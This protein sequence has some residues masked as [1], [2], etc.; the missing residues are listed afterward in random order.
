MQ[1]G[2]V[3]QTAADISEM[4]RDFGFKPTTDLAMG[5]EKLVAWY[6]DYYHNDGSNGNGN[7][8]GNSNNYMSSRLDPDPG[9][10]KYSAQPPWIPD[11]VRDDNIG[12]IMDL[13]NKVVLIT[14][15]A[16]GMERRLRNG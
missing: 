1:P 8:N 6:K 10:S 13:K 3:K 12:G 15:G 11:Q 9:E 14:G 5:L 4:N 7:G 2:D 16:S